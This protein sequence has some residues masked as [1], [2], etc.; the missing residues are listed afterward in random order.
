M[1][2]FEIPA[3]RALIVGMAAHNLKMLENYEIT[4]VCLDL[5]GAE[6]ATPYTDVHIH[7]DV[8]SPTY[9]LFANFAS[10]DQ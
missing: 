2:G 5:L 8:H 6:I 3:S 1:Y 7:I 4:N 10:G 9:S